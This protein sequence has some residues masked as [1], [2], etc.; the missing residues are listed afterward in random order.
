MF[1]GQL[2]LSGP[3]TPSNDDNLCRNLTIKNCTWLNGHNGYGIWTWAWSNVNISDCIAENWS[4]K[5]SNASGV[6]QGGGVA[7]IRN[8]PFWAH[9]FTVTGCQFRSR[10]EAQRTGDFAG[11]SQ[12]YSQ[13]NNMGAAS[14]GKGETLITSNN[15]INGGGSGGID[16]CIYFNDFG[17]LIFSNNNFENPII[18]HFKTENKEDPAFKV[19]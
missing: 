4:T 14:S 6:Y 3:N 9:G 1:K 16:E 5:Y 13:A 19:N 15:V 18:V 12:F 10:P 8:I 11:K 2:Y 17:S 7:F